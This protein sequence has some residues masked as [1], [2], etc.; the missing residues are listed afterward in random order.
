MLDFNNLITYEE[1][2]LLMHCINTYLE[3]LDF[4]IKNGKYYCTGSFVIKDL[5]NDYKKLVELQ[6]KIFLI[7]IKEFLD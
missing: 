6:K 2:S 5:E 4:V 1:K 7:E 3:K